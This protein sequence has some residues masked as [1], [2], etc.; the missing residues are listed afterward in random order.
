M[1]TSSLVQ[2]AL[3]ILL[4]LAFLPGRYLGLD[5]TLLM[6]LTVICVI[7]GIKLIIDGVNGLR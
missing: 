1:S 3:G 2:I 7:I 4:L 6:V 5:N